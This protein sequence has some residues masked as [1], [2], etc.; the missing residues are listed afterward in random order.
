MNNI[1][2]GAMAITKTYIIDVTATDFKQELVEGMLSTVVDVFRMN[3][4]GGVY[5]INMK[6]GE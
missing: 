4:H 3:E 6:V 5:E 2:G 1:K